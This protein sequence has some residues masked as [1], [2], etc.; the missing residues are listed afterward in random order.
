V[1]PT[2]LITRVFGAPEAEDHSFEQFVYGHVSRLVLDNYDFSSIKRVVQVGAHH[3]LLMTQLLMRH[4]DLEG[5]L[6]DSPPA[7]A[8]A[9]P[10]TRFAGVA[11]R[12]T[13]VT[14]SA[15]VSVPA[16][17]DAYIFSRVIENWGD[18]ASL[19][20]LANCRRVMPKDARLLLIEPMLTLPAITE[21]R[22][23][24]GRQRTEAQYAAL[25]AVAGL[26]LSDVI[27]TR[28]SLH[29][30]EARHAEARVEALVGA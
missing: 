17:G 3:S 9:R 21:I 15:L 10:F 20:I 12:C 30:L 7:L 24:S 29:I 5:V 23:A 13:I 11:D 6:F 26:T 16:G 4:P 25:L 28:S 27:P 14:G 19:R 22:G 1:I 2:T 8:S 18:T